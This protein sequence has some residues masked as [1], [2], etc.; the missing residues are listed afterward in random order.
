MRTRTL[1]LS[2]SLAALPLLFIGT[3]VAVL[4]SP[5][6]ASAQSS[7]EVTGWIPYWRTATGTADTLPHLDKLTEVNPFVFT[8]KQ[9]GTLFDNGALDQEPWLSFNAT[10]KSKGVRVIPTV[11]SGDRDL[12][13]KVLSDTQM[14][15]AL[16]D[17]I[18]KLVKDR[19]YDGIDIDFEFKRA[20]TKDYFS[21]FLKGLKQRLGDR[22]LMCTIETRIPLEDKYYGTTI[23]ADAG[24]F[25]NDL[26]AINTYCDRVRL[27][28]YDQQG[29]DLRLNSEVEATGELHAPVADPR[30]VEKVVNYMSKDIDKSKML[31][32]VPTYGYEYAV[33]TYANNQHVY[34]ILW[35]FNPGYAWPIAAEKGITPLRNSAGE[36]YFTYL[37]TIPVTAPTSESMPGNLAAAAAAAFATQNNSNITYRLI[38]WPDAYSMQ[39]KIDLAKRLGVRGISVFKFDG[40]QDPAIWNTLA[41]V[42]TA[43]TIPAA[44]PSAT[45]AQPSNPSTPGAIKGSFT[46]GLDLRSTGADVRLLQQFLNTDAATRVAASGAGS[47]GKETTYFGA[48]TAAAVKKFQVK[49][50]IAKAGDAGYGYV[51]P[52]TRA[53]LNQLLA[54]N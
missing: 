46:R 45:T 39:T 48:A 16:E 34:D 11:M 26:Q 51:G 54:S 18:A 33:T 3:A 8:L 41:G 6:F 31:I 28:A 43:N 12:M 25:S 30:W 9:D 23:P 52:K 44:P 14:R 53:Q 35:T 29:I 22:W 42:A 36:M 2:R 40:G 24:I 19:G 50:G 27:M 4:F 10:A 47:P 5:L 32:G 15:I 17:E 49:Y 13:H 7:F 1:A 38:T 37:S 20:E 21:T